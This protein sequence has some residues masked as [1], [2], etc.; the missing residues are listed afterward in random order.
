MNNTNEIKRNIF[1][2]FEN[3]RVLFNEYYNGFNHNYTEEDKKI[4]QTLIS[5]IEYDLENIKEEL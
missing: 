5:S 1:D 4:I 2:L 3:A